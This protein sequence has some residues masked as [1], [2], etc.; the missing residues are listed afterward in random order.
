MQYTININQRSVIENGWNLSFDDMAVFSFMKNFILEGALSKHV[1]HGKDYFWISFSKIREELPMLSGNSD[2]SIRRHISNLVRVGLIEK[3][4][5]EISIKNRIS[6]YRLGKSFSKY[7]HSVNPSKNDDTPP[8]LEGN[9]S[10]NERV[11][12]PNLEGNNNTSILDYQYQNISPNGGLSASALDLGEVKKEKTKTKSKKEPT[13]VTQG[14]N[15]FEAYFEKKTGEKYYWKAADGA[16]MK[17]LLNQ[18]KFSREHRGL[19]TSGKDLIDALQVF[20]DKITD[21]WM[22]ANLSVPNISSKYN[23]LVAQARKGKGQIGIILRNNTDDKYLNQ[24]IKQ[25]K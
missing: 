24:K 23:E 20:L 15:I 13:I 9:P 19:T 2:S 17:R 16:Q 14:R 8:N 5:D 10:K 11:T 25:W 6:L 21:N 3:C 18:L 7:W 12:P 22:L 1:I 4:D